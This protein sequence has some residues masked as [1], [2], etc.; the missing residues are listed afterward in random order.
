[1]NELLKERFF[2]LLSESSQEISNEEIQNAY[3]CFMEQVKT[4]SQSENNLSEI[5][6][7]LNI[8]R[9]ELVFIES[10]YQYEKEKKCYKICLSS[11]G[12][13]SCQFRT[14]TIRP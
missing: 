12:F 10:L 3:G 14:G 6:R 11:K 7:I 9:I 5:F 4:I 1:M 2:N 8:T 13:S